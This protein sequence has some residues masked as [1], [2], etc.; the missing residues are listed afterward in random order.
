MRIMEFDLFTFVI[1]PVLIFCARIIDV[2]IGTVRLIFISKGMKRLATTLGFFEVL[3]WIIA[4]SKLINNITHPILY[5][6]YALGFATG[7]YV[8]MK[9][10]EKLS[11]GKVMVRIIVQK[12]VKKLIEALR[13]TDHP[14]T[15]VNAEGKN[16]K[17]KMI[18]TIIER[19]DLSKIKSVIQ[20]I[21]PNAFYSVEDIKYARDHLHHQDMKPFG[22]YRKSK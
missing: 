22:S 3:I 14:I 7:T 10:E 9:I 4:I 6:A 11:F 12:D 15:F 16:G 8:G 19:R 13:E 5:F 18:F 21:N 1:L 2:S 17:V 20:K